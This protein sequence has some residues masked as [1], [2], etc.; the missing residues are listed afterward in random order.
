MRRLIAILLVTFLARTSFAEWTPDT[1]AE[2][3]RQFDSLVDLTDTYDRG[4]REMRDHPER[5]ADWRS[6]FESLGIS[7]RANGMQS[8]FQGLVWLADGNGQPH[9]PVGNA[10]LRDET[11]EQIIARGL[12]LHANAGVDYQRALVK[13]DAMLASY[14]EC[15]SGLRCQTRT[16]R[17]IVQRAIDLYDE[18][19]SAHSWT[20]PRLA[21]NIAFSLAAGSTDIRMKSGAAGPHGEYRV[22]W[23]RAKGAD[24]YFRH[25]LYQALLAAE[26]AN[27][28]TRGHLLRVGGLYGRMAR[29]VYIAS[30]LAVGY[31]HEM[32][33]DDIETMFAQGSTGRGR[34]F[35]TVTVAIDL[36]IGA[37]RGGVEGFPLNG[38]GLVSQRGVVDF[39]AALRGHY[40]RAFLSAN[41]DQPTIN[42]IA[43]SF[44]HLWDGW[45][46][47]DSWGSVGLIGFTFLNPPGG[48]PPPDPKCGFGTVEVDGKCVID[49]AFCPPAEFELVLD[50]RVVC[51]GPNQ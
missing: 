35:F 33:H 14:P 43:R 45:H 6:F 13:L 25:A 24:Q 37:P 32:V 49:L 7:S 31:E 5:I 3:G 12:N 44:E 22:G 28:E 2:V 41:G 39:V 34:S 38:F 16:V 36:T 40:F 8:A 18:F 27:F 42:L 19:D 30:A 46:L 1:I 26:T 29:R 10:I 4:F 17:I 21:E 11:R 51:Q 47:A 50:G 23:Q 48:P 15:A 9:T 20:E